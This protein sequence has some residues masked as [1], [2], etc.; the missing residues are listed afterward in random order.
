MVKRSKPLK[1]KPQL[2]TMPRQPIPR[3][4]L[5]ENAFISMVSAAVEAYDH[6]T[7]GV[8]L[9]LRE[10]RRR[11]KFLVVGLVMTTKNQCHL[12]K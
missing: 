9:G 8:L 11:G 6:E 10:P 12:V 5:S 2:L 1:R 3:V 7:L 4:W